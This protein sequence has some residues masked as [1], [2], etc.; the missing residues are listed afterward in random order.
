MGDFEI[1]AMWIGYA[2]MIASGIALAAVAIGVAVS[3]FGDAL[4]RVYD[5]AKIADMVRFCEKRKE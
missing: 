5:F 4:V 3:M 2:V 1:T